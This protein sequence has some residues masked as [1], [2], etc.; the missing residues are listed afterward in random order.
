MAKMKF[1]RAVTQP[2]WSAEKS[3][4]FIEH[5]SYGPSTEMGLDWKFHV[6]ISD[7]PLL[8]EFVSAQS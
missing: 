5:V 2:Q 4:N 7:H 6:H 1:K 3:Q 8:V